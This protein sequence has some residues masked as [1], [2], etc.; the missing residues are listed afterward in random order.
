MPTPTSPAGTP[1]V[2]PAQITVTPLTFT[3]DRDQTARLLVFVLDT[4]TGHFTAE[5]WDRARYAATSNNLPGYY[6]NR[7]LCFIGDSDGRGGT[8]W[9]NRT[10]RRLAW[11]P[12][13]W[14]TYPSDAEQF[15]KVMNLMARWARELVDVLEP[16]PDG[17]YDWTLRATA[18]YERI[19][20]LANYGTRG[21][22]GDK[23]DS[24]DPWHGDGTAELPQRHHYGAVN[25]DEIV[26]AD[27][28]WAD[29]RWA[30]MTDAQLDEVAAGVYRPYGAG[31]LAKPLTETA[32]TRLKATVRFSKLFR[33]DES[34]AE[35]NRSLPLH[36]VGVREGLRRWR[37]ARLAAS[38]GMPAVDATA[39]LA[40][41]LPDRLGA[42][43][44][45]T[46]LGEL[47]RLVAVEAAH[48]DKVA[49]VGA[50]DYL[51]RARAEMRTNVRFELATIVAERAAIA[52]H[53]A[54][55]TARR[56]SLLAA[57]VAFREEPEWPDDDAAEPNYAELGRLAGMTRQAALEQLRPL[58]AGD[59]ADA[60][61]E[62]RTE[63]HR[64]VLRTIRD[65]EYGKAYLHE[66]DTALTNAGLKL[67]RSVTAALIAGLVDQFIITP[68]SG[69]S[70]RYQIGPAGQKEASEA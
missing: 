39:H 25:F 67:R 60:E 28:D 56:A 68:T 66:I 63:A 21:L 6:P 55:L 10:P 58:F 18:A 47:A 4:E 38:T 29:P 41:K 17:G 27:P 8:E 46:E 50:V 59:D 57:V 24:T 7:D 1:Y 54:Q 43:T 53:L 16:L 12:R 31:N 37:A 40:G 9:W 30:A 69:H 36:P 11:Q 23:T 61:A 13:Q 3:L 64:V 48:T 33:T 52:A 65:G 45:D 44:G 5:Q 34:L 22:L 62:K 19:A 14:P 20:Y 42:T 51:A 49:L 70:S 2:P 32:V 15:R 35:Q 26:D